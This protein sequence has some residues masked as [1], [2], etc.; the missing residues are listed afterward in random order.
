MIMTSQLLRSFSVLVF[1]GL[2]S[3]LHAETW[4]IDPAHSAVQFSV[5]HLGI[6]TVRGT[7][8]KLSGTVVYDPA[9]PASA[10]LNV[11]IDANSIDTR[12]E[13]RDNDLRSDHFFDV[14]KYPTITFKSTQVEAA[15]SGKLKVV[16]D[17]TLHGVTKS[18]TL[19]IE[20]PTEPMKDQR[21]KVHMGASGTTKVNRTEFGMTTMPGVVGTDIGI[22]IDAEMVQA[23]APS[24]K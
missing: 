19:D 3:A 16:G 15:G 2:P 23:E 17:L 13:R 24:A 6:S 18:V 11:T 14:A 8:T 10:S 7:F 20:G 5:R 9:Q 22:T 21:G 4:Q 12:V 1:C